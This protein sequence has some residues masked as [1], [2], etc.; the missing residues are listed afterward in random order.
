MGAGTNPNYNPVFTL[1]QK[2]PTEVIQKI[3]DVVFSSERADDCMGIRNLGKCFMRADKNRNMYLNRHEFTWALK[4]N[5]H[6]L[7]KTELDRLFRFFDKNGDDQ[8]S[9]MCLIKA[10]RGP[11][12]DCI[13]KQLKAAWNSISNNGA[14]SHVSLCTF[15]GLCDKAMKEKKCDWTRMDYAQEI[16]D[17]FLKELGC[18]GDGKSICERAFMCYYLDVTPC[19]FS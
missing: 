5:G 3:K 17:N 13:R 2:P 15:K 4:E 8:V 18:M 9:Y 10:L 11:I 16:V 1:L 6:C 19:L 12:S 7:T 14:D